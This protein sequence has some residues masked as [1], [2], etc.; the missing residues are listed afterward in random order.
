[1]KKAFQIQ[2][3]GRVQG[4]GFRYYT[5]AKA[6]EAGVFGF[7]KNMPDGSVFIEAEG[8]ESALETF[9]RWCRQGPGRAKVTRFHVNPQPPCGYN[10]F[11]IR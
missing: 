8:D 6:Q 4:V 10:S 1:M 3:E 9:S 2:I 5:R 7:V 11:E